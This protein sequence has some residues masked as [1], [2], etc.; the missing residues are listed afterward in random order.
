MNCRQCGTE[1]V[2]SMVTEMGATKETQWKLQGEPVFRCPAGCRSNQ[3]ET[4]SWQKLMREKPK[5][6]F[7]RKD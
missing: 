6:K 2:P 3:H 7:V 4:E 5:P 1:L